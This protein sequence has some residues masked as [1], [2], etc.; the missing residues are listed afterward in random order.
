MS[1]NYD[2]L[3]K[4]GNDLWY[5]FNEYGIIFLMNTSFLILLINT[6]SMSKNKDKNKYI[7][8]YRNANMFTLL[9]FALSIFCFVI[10]ILTN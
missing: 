3:I 5:L 7:Q 8:I 2:K 6:L 10:K 1:S 9:F 4:L